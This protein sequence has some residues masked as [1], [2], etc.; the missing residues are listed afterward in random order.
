MSSLRRL[1]DE[2]E[3]PALSGVL[4]ACRVRAK[5]SAYADDIIVF[6]SCRL[7]ILTVKKAV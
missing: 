2:K 4:F 1:R 6:V 3:N 7:D 5:V